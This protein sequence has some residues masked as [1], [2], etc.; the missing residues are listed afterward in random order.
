MSDF[1]DYAGVDFSREFLAH[2]G[3]GHLD[4]GKSGR[5]KWG[6]GDRPYQRTSM[7]G[8][9]GSHRVGGTHLTRAEK[10][11]RK[12]QRDAASDSEFIW[13][14]D[15]PGIRKSAGYAMRHPDQFNSAVTNFISKHGGMKV[16]K[17]YADAYKEAFEKEIKLMSTS[18]NDS[19]MARM[20]DAQANAK[21]RA[22]DKAE[23]KKLKKESNTSIDQDI[24][25]INAELKERRQYA[26]S[27]GL[28]KADKKYANDMLKESRNAAISLVG[29][30]ATFKRNINDEIAKGKSVK[31]I[32]KEWGM[33]EAE[34]QQGKSVSIEDYASRLDLDKEDMQ[35]IHSI[36]KEKQAWDEYNKA[37]RDAYEFKDNSKA[38][39]KDLEAKKKAANAASEERVRLERNSV[40]EDALKRG[41]VN[42]DYLSDDELDRYYKYQAKNEA[43]K[44][45]RKIDSEIKELR[46]ELKKHPESASDV[47]MAYSHLR[48]DASAD[49]SSGKSIKEIAKEADMPED[50]V[51][52]AI[53]E[54]TSDFINRLGL[55]E[56]T[57]KRLNKKYKD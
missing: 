11:R 45:S 16:S 24:D 4:G 33:S 56:Q 34:I 3:K 50:L 19:V 14:E 51:R 28:T 44:V 5:Y 7:E 55:D 38:T 32:A 25:D 21:F 37:Y 13:Q 39:L 30:F 22:V 36:A 52:L 29:S 41:E 8:K 35:R 26:N 12:A 31:D 54:P 6:S 42:I 2:Y 48:R 40:D 27:D 15:A 49:V 20:K 9:G 1:R 10:Q 53:L 17:E 43:N 57:A 18:L 47:V 23:L 46:S